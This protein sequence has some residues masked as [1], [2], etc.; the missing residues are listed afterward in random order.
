MGPTLALLNESEVTDAGVETFPLSAAL[1]AEP[2]SK[3]AEPEKHPTANNINVKNNSIQ[4]L[5]I[6]TYFILILTFKINQKYK[7]IRST[8]LCV[9]NSS[10]SELLSGITLVVR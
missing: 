9:L 2:K 7:I 6:P 8:E 5:D 4:I 3:T 10:T 1:A